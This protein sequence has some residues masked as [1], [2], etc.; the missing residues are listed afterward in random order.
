QQAFVDYTPVELAYLTQASRVGYIKA[1]TLYLVADH[2]A[3]AA[4]LRQLLPR[5]L[6]VF[7]KLEA[8]ITGIKVEVQVSDPSRTVQRKSQKPELPIDFI[9][10]FESLMHE[11][12]D[13]QLKLAITNFVRKRPKKGS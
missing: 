2:A 5:L 8:E 11:I 10:K 12:R 4:K 9:D 13:P 1:G 7:R 6:P 3:V